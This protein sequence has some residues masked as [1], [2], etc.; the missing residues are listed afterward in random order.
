MCFGSAVT[1]DDVKTKVAPP[2]YKFEEHCDLSF[3]FH[4]S[5]FSEFIIKRL[6][7]RSPRRYLFSRPAPGSINRRIE[8]FEN[9][10]SRA[11]IEVLIFIDC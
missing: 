5:E 2:V 4:T 10:S 6:D 3:T 8:G 11:A 9:G 1:D 7:N